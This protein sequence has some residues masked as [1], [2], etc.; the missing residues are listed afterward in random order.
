MN[1][2]RSIF[3]V[4]IGLLLAISVTGTQ[5]Q[6]ATIV[7]VGLPEYLRNTLPN[8]A[9]AAF[10]SDHPGV[11][12]QPVFIGLDKLF[13]PSPASGINDYLDAVQK[14]V[15]TADVVFVNNPEV[16]PAA[17]RAGY[18][19]DLSS[20]VS[21]DSSLNPADYVNGA[22]G[23]YQWDN[24]F[25][26]LPATVD[27]VGL[28]YDPAAFDAAGIAYPNAAWTLDDLASAAD[29]LA[30]RD[31]SGNVTLPGLITAGDANILLRSLSGQS[32]IDTASVPN[33]PQL[34]QPSLE[35]QLNK[36]L[37]IY[38]D[39]VFATQLSNPD[40]LNRIPMQIGSSSIFARPTFSPNATAANQPKLAV[41]PL[42]GGLVG[43]T[44]QGFAVSAAT[45]Q[46]DLAYQVAKYITETPSI[47]SVLGGGRPARQNL[48]DIQP[49]PAPS[50]SGGRIVINGGG[51][52]L[53]PQAQIMID[54][55]IQYAIPASELNFS[56]YLSLALQN[57]NA[58]TDIHAALQSAEAQAISDL[59]T[60][61]DRKG[62]HHLRRRYADPAGGL[63]ARR[64]LA[65]LLGRLPAQYRSMGHAAAPVRRR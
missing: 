10:E 49:T 26:A 41:S 28:I 17:T 56:D 64:N 3:W 12:V 65:A 43:L 22:W 18:Y 37:K 45:I 14:L 63:A 4:A 23:S 57:A 47:L 29:K 39:G 7:T 52:P 62:K 53:S 1:Y 19:L 6:G 58:N 48:T 16:T 51:L 36:W 54:S 21:A 40:D 31:S 11:Q 60:A 9:F 46:P 38:S 27:T 32:L 50:G 33:V 61:A 55:L 24:G 5:A 35:T 2:L 25:W 20:V 13:I 44:A 59:Q 30:Q 42:P 15:S 34:A 8:D